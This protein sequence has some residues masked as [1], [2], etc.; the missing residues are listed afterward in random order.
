MATNIP[1]HNLREVV[2]AI[3]HMIDNPDATPGDLRK[4]IKGPDLPTAAYIYGRAGIRDYQET[5]RGRI[6][7]RARAVIEEKESSNKSQIVITEFPY[8]VNPAKL[9]KDIAELVRDKKL[10]GISDLRN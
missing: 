2:T 4:F 7:M 8:Q 6:I 1:P 9:E 5:G 10:E 3:V